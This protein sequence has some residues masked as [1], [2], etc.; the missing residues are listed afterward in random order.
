MGLYLIGIGGT[1]AK[2]VEAVAKLAAMGLFTEE[3]I[4][5]LFVDA[6]ETNGNLARARTSIGTYKRTYD[7]MPTGDKT[8]CG[9]MKSKI[10]SFDHWSPFAQEKELR[11]FFNYNTIKQN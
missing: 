11:T 6:D 1:G 3:P 8:H 9:W 7:L 5:V 10:E 2:C 4:K